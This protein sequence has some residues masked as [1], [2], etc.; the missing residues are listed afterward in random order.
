MDVTPWC[1]KWMDGQEGMGMESIL[2]M[3]IL[4]SLDQSLNLKYQIQITCDLY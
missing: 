4:L 1:Y 2:F 3:P